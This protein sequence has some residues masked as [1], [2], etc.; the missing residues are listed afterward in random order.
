[1]LKV[2]RLRL[3]ESEKCIK[4]WDIADHGSYFSNANPRAKTLHLQH[5]L[6]PAPLKEFLDILTP[7][8]DIDRPLPVKDPEVLARR[9]PEQ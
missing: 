7:V 5:I 8:L 6:A 9:K 2:R 3:I 4:Y 1:M